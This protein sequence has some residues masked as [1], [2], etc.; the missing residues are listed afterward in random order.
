MYAIQCPYI[1]KSFNNTYNKGIII[2]RVTEV[3]ATSNRRGYYELSNPLKLVKNK[4]KY[5]HKYS[6]RCYST[7]VYVPEDMAT[8][9]LDNDI[10][11]FSSFNH[12]Y[13]AKC[14]LLE[15]LRV[16]YL[17]ALVE[18]QTRMERNCP[19]VKADPLMFSEHHP[20]HFI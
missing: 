5:V 11:L 12:A 4:W 16:E 20:E 18:L 14:I 9:P 8:I 13:V 10:L 15:R 7:R 2:F 6:D 3:F 1:S 17:K 19:N